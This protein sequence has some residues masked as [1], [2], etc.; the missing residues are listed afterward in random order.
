VARRVATL[1]TASP[2]PLVLLACMDGD[3]QA[4]A[5][6]HRRFASARV[7]GEWFRPVPA[8]LRFLLAGAQQ[9]G[10]MEMQPARPVLPA[11]VLPNRECK[12]C[13]LLFSSP[14]CP[15]CRRVCYPLRGTSVQQN[16]PEGC[17]NSPAALTTPK[18]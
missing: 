10:R 2:A 12:R 13:A 18:T 11:P 1:Q 9:G 17:S 4:E 7:R 8:L 16:E 3:R 6:L 14:V 15:K 5:R